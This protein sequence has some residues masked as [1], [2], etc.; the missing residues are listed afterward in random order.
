MVKERP[1]HK[2]TVVKSVVGHKYLALCSVSLGACGGSR[3]GFF[4]FCLETVVSLRA[5]KSPSAV[6]VW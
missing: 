5:A 1:G 4:S 6:H 2:E 3:E